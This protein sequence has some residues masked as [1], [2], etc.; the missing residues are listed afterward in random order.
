MAKNVNTA[1]PLKIDQRPETSYMGVRFIAPPGDKPTLS[2]VVMLDDLRLY[3][4]A[5]PP[6]GTVAAAGGVTGN[7]YQY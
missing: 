2:G 4:T 1:T 6:S 7:V 5:N 3:P